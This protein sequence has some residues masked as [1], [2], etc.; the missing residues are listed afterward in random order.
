MSEFQTYFTLG[1]QH[2]LDWQGYDHMIF[3]LALIAPLYLKEW[4]SILI[5]I[6]AFTIG[7][8]ISLLITTLNLISVN[9][10]LI[11]LLIPIT[12]LITSILNITI[13]KSIRK[14]NYSITLIFGFIHGM[15]FSGYLK[16]LLGAEQ[17]LVTPLLSFNLGL[18]FGQIIFTVAT[19]LIVSLLNI[20]LSVK[21]R[22]TNLVLSGIALAVS[23]FLILERI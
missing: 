21:H 6:T 16:S 22:T 7:H 15:G 8:S 5:L 3:L 4:R 10:D 1:Y 9:P 12:I 11:E 2:I 14:V 13:H 19:V 23:I 18:E 17:N 20:F